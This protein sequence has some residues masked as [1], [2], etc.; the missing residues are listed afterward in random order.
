MNE[1]NVLLI[2]VDHWFNQLLGC[3]GHETIMTPT[4]D[5]L[6]RN[7]IIYDNCYSE[8]PVCI[9]ARRTLMT[10]TSPRT[11]GDRV[12]SDTMPMPVGIPTLAET[13][14]KAGYQTFAV[15][16]LHVYPQ[17]DRIGFDD[18]I[19]LE[20]GRYDF[21]VVDDYQIWLGEQGYI[22]EEFYHCMG[23]NTYYTR[24]FH[25][26]EKAHPINWVTDQAIKQI[27]RKDPTKPG[28]FYVSYQAPHPPL[29]PLSLYMDMYSDSE[30][31]SCVYGAWIEDGNY[32]VD[33]IKDMQSQYSNKEIIRAKKAFYA[34]CTHVDQQIRLLIGT[35][36]EM[37]LLDNTII[38]FLSDHGD[39]LFDHE[40]VA[41]RCFYERSSNVPLILS[42]KPVEE[43]GFNIKDDRLVTLKD[44]MPTL[45]ELCDIE[46]P[47]TVDGR[48]I[49]S[50]ETYRHI[51]G[52]VGTD[53]KATR[54]IRKDQYK[55]IYYPCGNRYQL[56]DIVVDP[57]E[58]FD[59]VNKDDKKEIV[60]ELKSLLEKE[61][62]GSDLQWYDKDKLVGIKEQK[63]ESKAD[64]AMYNQRGGHW[65]PPSGYKN[66]GANA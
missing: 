64:Y 28:F 39:M 52:E 20:E 25:L 31:D 30:I 57:R 8:C 45:L 35:L 43:I 50:H 53:I 65:P 63:F 51:Y 22:G 48:S 27:K 44:I 5:A 34:L 54:M 16:K 9:P 19:I 59:L 41:K 14:K 55:L 15:G 32:C 66:K 62:Y 58:C 10:G 3:N 29:V 12:Y 37:N 42:G 4:L 17:R 61:L 24:P 56:F 40:M 60:E 33:N 1:N 47:S 2:N 49:L 23:N 21:G 13:F 11:H 6:A 46:V 36:R 26:P 38:M 7:G 18:A